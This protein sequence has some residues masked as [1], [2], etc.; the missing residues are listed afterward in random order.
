MSRTHI[1]A[2][3]TYDHTIRVSDENSTKTYTRTQEVELEGTV[4]DDGHF[5]DD[6]TDG[7]G[8]YQIDGD[9]VTYT[10]TDDYTY[11]VGTD[12]TLTTDDEQDGG[13]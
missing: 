9:S 7:Y 1:P 4:D 8:Y 13:N 12:G 11:E 6:S 3:L 5:R 2:T 10:R